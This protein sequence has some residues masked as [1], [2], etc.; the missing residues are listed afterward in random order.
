MLALGLTREINENDIYAV[1]N[2]MRSDQITEM[3]AKQW[4]LELEKENLSILRV[5]WK[6]YGLKILTISIVCSIL[7]QVVK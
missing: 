2:D 4:Q 5:V 3:F 6:L 1:T 7:K